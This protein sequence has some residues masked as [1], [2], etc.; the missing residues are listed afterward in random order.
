MS[1]IYYRGHFFDYP[2]RP[3]NALRG[4]GPLEAARVVASYLHC[5]A[6]PDRDESTFDAWVSNRFGPAPLRDLLQD[7]HR[8][9]LGHA[10]LGDQRDLGG[11]AHQEPQPHDRG[12]EGFPSRARDQTAA[13][14]SPASSSASTTRASGP[15]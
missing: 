9:G 1:R 5:P 7:L 6:L 13:R 2:L 8:E 15:G 10:L 14:S 3:A 12:Q 11:A 4:L